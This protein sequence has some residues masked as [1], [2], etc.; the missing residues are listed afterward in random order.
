MK[1]LTNNY[2]YFFPTKFEY[3][4]LI[5]ERK[6]TTTKTANKVPFSELIMVI[7]A[8]FAF[9]NV[10]GGSSGVAYLNQQICFTM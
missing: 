5:L 4:N 3:G 6:T 7:F 9:K 2:I 1:I 10:N 8:V